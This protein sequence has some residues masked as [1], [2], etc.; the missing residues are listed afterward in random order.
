MYGKIEN[1]VLQG[2]RAHFNLYS[3]VDNF[4]N[5]YINMHMSLSQSLVS[6]VLSYACEMWG[7]AKAK[8]LSW[9]NLNF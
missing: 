9:Y 8:K 1:I 7:F 2:H 5:M 6:S 4:E 3:S